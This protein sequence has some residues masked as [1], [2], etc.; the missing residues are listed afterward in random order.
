MRKK[1]LHLPKLEL[2]SFTKRQKFIVSVGIL[3][4]GLLIAE[5]LLGR[6]GI[7]FSIVLSFASVLFFIGC[8]YKDMKRNYSLYVYVLPL[9]MYTL[10]IGLFYFLIPSRVITR[11][12]LTTLYALGIYSLYLSQNIFIVASLRTIPLLSGA[13]IVSFVTTFFSYLLL[14]I[15]VFSLHLS[16]LL[17]A[18][19]IFIIS[20]I[21]T[22][23]SIAI[24]Y[25]KSLKKSLLWV[26]SLSLCLVELAIILWYWPTTPTMIAIFLSVFFNAIVGLSRVW[27]EKRLFRGVLWEYI[28]IAVIVFCIFIAFTTWK[29]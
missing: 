3:S 2:F 11:L 1:R 22:F 10:A 15:V 23:Q 21:A 13:R 25:E 8:E 4:G 18:L 17:T 6:S 27:L 19:G 5:Q 16:I 7:F 12:S 14:C 26:C 9:F 28:W 29:G 20:F 24:S